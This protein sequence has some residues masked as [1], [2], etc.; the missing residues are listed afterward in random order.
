M[1]VPVFLVVGMVISSDGDA[2]E[3]MVNA[4]VSRRGIVWE[5]KTWRDV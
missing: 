1:V 3:G 2:G 4:Q 5:M